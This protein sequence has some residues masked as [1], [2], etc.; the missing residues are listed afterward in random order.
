VFDV[1]LRQT[2]KCDLRDIARILYEKVDIH[3]NLDEQS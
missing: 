1:K 2:A 3:R